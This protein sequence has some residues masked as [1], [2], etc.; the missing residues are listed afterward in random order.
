ML[1]EGL[2]RLRHAILLPR[3]MMAVRRLSHIESV[4]TGQGEWSCRLHK[5]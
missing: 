2:Q 3:R 4:H 1:R 5:R